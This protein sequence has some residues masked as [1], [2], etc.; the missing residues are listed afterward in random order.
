MRV[1]FLLAFGLLLPA[2]A[3]NADQLIQ[4]PTADRVSA[5][6]AEYRH[7]VDGRNEGYATLLTPAGPG[8][9]AM[10]RYYNNED[11]SH[12]IEG[13]GQFQLL[14]DGVVT[15]ALA[16]GMWD[17]TNSTPWGR[18]AFL[19]ITKSFTRFGAGLFNVPAPLERLQ[20]TFGAGTGR[21]GGGF[22]GLRADL[23][24]RLSL[25][26]EFDSR[27]LNTGLSFRPL[28]PLSLTAELQ[29]GNPYLGAQFRASF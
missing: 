20:F 4:I 5:P 10:F 29:N 12:R 18:R 16:V 14:P 28:P 2:A 26:A 22:A 17:V 6:K 11:R 8:F 13:G 21:L 1:T 9:E 24:G 25:I 23:P 27:R 19:A 3:A 7:R 15:P